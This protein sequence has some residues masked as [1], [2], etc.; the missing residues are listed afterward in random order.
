MGSC[1]AKDA[2]STKGAQR[3]HPILGGFFAPFAC[4]AVQGLSFPGEQTKR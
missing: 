4:F 1:T 2:K 3:G